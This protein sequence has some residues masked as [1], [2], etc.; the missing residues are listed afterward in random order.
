M[1]DGTSLQM[2][3]YPGAMYN[4][5]LDSRVANGKSPRRDSRVSE[6]YSETFLSDRYAAPSACCR[7]NLVILLPR[8]TSICS[9]RPLIAALGIF[10]YL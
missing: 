2:I 8:V 4:N 9:L 5:N 3:A 10:M 1:G 7:A 6:R